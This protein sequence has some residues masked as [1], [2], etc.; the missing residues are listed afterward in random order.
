MLTKN[1][2]NH[3][4]RKK[5]KSREL[6]NNES[7]SKTHYQTVRGELTNHNLPIYM[8]QLE[9]VTKFWILMYTKQHMKKH[10]F[11]GDL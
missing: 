3:F 9:F 4:M 1:T 6:I 8:P 2:Y 5:I 7:T 11:L 10:M